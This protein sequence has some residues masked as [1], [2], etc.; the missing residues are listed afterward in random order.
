MSDTFS[1]R[2]SE[3]T[4]EL[5]VTI[6]RAWWFSANERRHWADK[7]DRTRHVRVAGG[8]EARRAGIAD[9]RRVTVCAY[10]G[11]PRAGRADPSNAAPMVKAL[12]DGLTDAGVWEDDDSEHV[13]AVTY[14]RGAPSGHAGEWRVRL[15]IEEVA[16]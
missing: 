8:W 7:A 15:V 10:I 13:V 9:H 12:L 14:R 5:V 11:Y 6:P 4:S 1:E 16:E 2:V 3:R